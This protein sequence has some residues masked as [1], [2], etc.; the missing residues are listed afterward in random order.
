MDLLFSAYSSIQ[1][2]FALCASERP[3]AHLTA[4]DNNEVED[5]V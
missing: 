4:I 3:V 1:F 2:Q 5:D